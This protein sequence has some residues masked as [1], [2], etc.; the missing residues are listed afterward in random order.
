MFQRI[1]MILLILSLVGYA[2]AQDTDTIRSIIEERKLQD[3]SDFSLSNDNSRI[4]ILNTNGDLSVYDIISDEV[5]LTLNTNSFNATINTISWSADDRL[6]AGAFSD[7]G[8]IWDSQTGELIA[9]LE[10]HPRQP[11]FEYEGK[12]VYSIVFSPAGS[13]FASYAVSDATVLLYDIQTQEIIYHLNEH[14]LDSYI[15]GVTFSPNGLYLAVQQI[16]STTTIWDTQTGNKLHQFTGEI[17]AFSPDSTLLA[18]GTGGSSSNIWIWNLS[19][20]EQQYE[21]STLSRI[22]QLKWTSDGQM[23]YGLFQ[24]P[25]F[26]G[27]WNYS[28]QGVRSWNMSDWTDHHFFAQEEVI[29]LPFVAAEQMTILAVDVDHG[30]GRLLIWDEEN[31]KAFVHDL[32]SEEHEQDYEIY[33][34]IFLAFDIN[35]NIDL[36]VTSD[37][38]GIRLWDITTKKYL[39]VAIPNQVRRI[40]FLSD[41]KTII[42]LT[43]KKELLFWTIENE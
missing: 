32:L 40:V 7:K 29:R 18:T 28:G 26:T 33:S 25:F 43:N 22:E 5:T 35:S 10:E 30:E 38:D 2:D 37:I 36:M 9:E 21:I 16:N 8:R 1:F 17:I 4:L 31:K 24:P 19:N 39:S 11:I 6:I 14:F 13:L 41:D 34:T 23:L 20:G 15:I 27:E 3:I 12:S 42:G